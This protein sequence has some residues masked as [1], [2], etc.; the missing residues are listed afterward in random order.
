M[1]D[2]VTILLGGLAALC[3]IFVAADCVWGDALEDLMR[4]IRCIGLVVIGLAYFG[5][6]AAVVF[7]VL[8]L[9]F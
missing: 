5:V 6:I 4:L 3:M 2:D 9:L 7:K 8:T 1:G